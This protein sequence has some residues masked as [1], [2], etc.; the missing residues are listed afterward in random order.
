M[1]V[2]SDLRGTM[3]GGRVLALAAIAATTVAPAQ[4][5]DA[6]VAFTP[7]SAWT[8]DYADT[9]CALRRNFS[10]DQGAIQLQVVSFVDANAYRFV[11]LSPDLPLDR[12]DVIVRVEPDDGDRPINAPTF[13]RGDGQVRGAWFMASVFPASVAAGPDFYPGRIPESEHLA[14]ERAIEGVS[15]SGVYPGVVFLSTGSLAGPMEALRACMDD[16][17]RTW[18][19]DPSLRDAV[20][21]QPQRV[22]YN[23][24]AR[25]IYDA[26]PREMV[27]EGHSAA[28]HVLME[29]SPEGRVAR[30]KAHNPEPLPQ[31]EEA[32]CATIL[33]RARYEPARDAAGNAVTGFDTMIVNFATW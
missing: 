13:T 30:C 33:Q 4:G 15:V 21:T 17:W 12:G 31:F 25:R 29:V 32:A 20:A 6:P 28:V 2:G 10:S 1:I 27:R 7:S 16:L 19:F 24:L 8:V 14:R 5:R 3:L 23:G 11:L 9:S 22:G 26:Y 18:G